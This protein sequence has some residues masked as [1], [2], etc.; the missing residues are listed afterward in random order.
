MKWTE[1]SVSKI[2]LTEME[3]I[4]PV[5]VFLETV[6]SQLNGGSKGYLTMVFFDESFSA[7]WPSM[8][9]NK[10]I[11]EFILGQDIEYLAQSLAGER[12]AQFSWGLF[13][14]NAKTAILRD[15]KERLISKDDARERWD[16]ASEMRPE[17]YYFDDTLNWDT[18]V[19]A[20]G[21]DWYAHIPKM[22]TPLGRD[23]KIGLTALKQ[24][25][26]ERNGVS[27]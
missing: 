12:I 10:T 18:I 19:A 13:I 14:N 3:R 25:L 15:R 1:S 21:D 26:M 16:A 8:G 5:T 27:A 11:E 22:D 7:R 2:E 6:P 24:C 23:L 20:A 17:E 4:D 9:H